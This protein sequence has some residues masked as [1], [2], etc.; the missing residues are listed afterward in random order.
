[1]AGREIKMFNTTQRLVH[2]LHVMAFFTLALTG[3]V[4]YAPFLQGLAIGYAGWTIRLI[5]RLGAVLLALAALIYLIFSPRALF[6]SLKRIFTWTKDDWGWFK[7]APRYY[8]LGDEE[9]MPPQDKFNAGQKLFYIT[10]LVGLVLFGITGALMW[11]GKF[12]IPTWL[13]QWS[14][15]IHDL[16]FIAY[17]AFFLVH[18]MLSVA[19]PLMKG[20]LNGMLFGWMPEEYVKHHHARYYEELTSKE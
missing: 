19:H 7:A 8:F 16:C 9:G 3:L 12:Y 20:A 1:M 5:H 11:F 15:L 18:F 13:F 6:G 17:V 4:L 14:V 2:W 10:V